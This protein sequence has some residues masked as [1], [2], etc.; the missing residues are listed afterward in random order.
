[1]ALL[2]TKSNNILGLKCSLHHWQ[3]ITNWF[4]ATLPTAVC[5]IDKGPLTDLCAVG[6]LFPNSQQQYEMTL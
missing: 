5:N 1:M 2:P 4:I 3:Q 6:N